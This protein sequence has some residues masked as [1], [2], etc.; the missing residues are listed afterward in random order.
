MSALL[1]LAWDEQQKRQA[2][3]ILGGLKRMADG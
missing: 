2:A 1:P 3:L